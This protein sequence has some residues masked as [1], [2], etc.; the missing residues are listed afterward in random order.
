[1]EEL[2]CQNQCQARTSFPQRPPALTSAVTDE[3]QRW[4]VFLR[5]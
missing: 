5:W 3:F 4:S 2:Q 1:M